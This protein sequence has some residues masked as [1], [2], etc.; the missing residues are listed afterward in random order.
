MNAEDDTRSS[1]FYIAFTENYNT[2]FDFLDPFY[3]ICNCLQK[4]LLY[5]Y[6]QYISNN[7][8][9][10]KK[11]SLDAKYMYPLDHFYYSEFSNHVTINFRKSIN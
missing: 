9:P 6:I 8:H 5:G 2:L 7:R 11:S 10:I 3:I 4:Q 1:S